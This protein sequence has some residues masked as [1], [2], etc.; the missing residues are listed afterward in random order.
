MCLETYELDPTRFLTAPVITWQGTFNKTKIR[1]VRLTEID[2]F[3][4][5]KWQIFKKEYL[6]LFIDMQKIITY[7]WKIMIKIVVS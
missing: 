2:V 4:G 7:T 3:N 6:M 5:R 1:F